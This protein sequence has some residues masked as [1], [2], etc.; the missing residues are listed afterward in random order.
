[1]YGWY[2]WDLCWTG[3][4]SLTGVRCIDFQAQNLVIAVF[5]DWSGA[6]CISLGSTAETF[7]IPTL[8]PHTYVPLDGAA[9]P[10]YEYI[11]YDFGL[12]RLMLTDNK[13]VF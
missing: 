4:A 2:N 7:I 9:K 8:Y 10:P 12:A 5:H 13:S 1:M 6:L 3:C 11:A